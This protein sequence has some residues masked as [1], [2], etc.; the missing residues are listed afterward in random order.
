VDSNLRQ[1]RFYFPLALTPLISF[2][3]QLVRKLSAFK[4]PEKSI[5]SRSR[6]QGNLRA[7]FAKQDSTFIKTNWD[8]KTISYH[9]QHFVYDSDEEKFLAATP[10]NTEGD[11]LKVLYFVRSG[12]NHNTAKDCSFHQRCIGFHIRRKQLV[13]T[14]GL[15][16]STSSYHIR[17][18]LQN[19]GGSLFL[20]K[21]P[22]TDW[23]PSDY[24]KQRDS[25]FL[26]KAWCN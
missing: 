25:Q 22:V 13:A 16:F 24:S 9:S 1:G 12:K 17:T 6:Q 10:P 5:A 18:L 7:T 21:L 14:P 8:H 23:C 20:R 4:R 11:L 15:W 3:F 26:P 19:H 2:A